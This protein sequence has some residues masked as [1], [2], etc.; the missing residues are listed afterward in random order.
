MLDEKVKAGTVVYG[1]DGQEFQVMEGKTTDFVIAAKVIFNNP[2]VDNGQCLGEYE[3][4]QRSELFTA[5][6]ATTKSMLDTPKLDL[7]KPLQTRKQARQLVQIIEAT[8]QHYSRPGDASGYNAGLDNLKWL[9]DEFVNSFT[10]D[11]T[12]VKHKLTGFLN[13]YDDYCGG[14]CKT[15]KIARNQ[16]GSESIACIDLSKLGIEYEEGDGL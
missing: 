10:S 9:Q 7:S 11:P 6:P 15:K 8:A 14:W 1:E 2:E 12:P 5:P 16:A 13:V 3:I 4:K